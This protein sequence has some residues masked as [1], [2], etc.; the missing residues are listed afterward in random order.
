MTAAVGAGVGEGSGV[1]VA[2]GVGT[3]TLLAACVPGSLRMRIS[4]TAAPVEKRRIAMPSA[5]ESLFATAR[6]LSA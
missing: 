2:A 5:G 4:A 3:A 6:T 1:A